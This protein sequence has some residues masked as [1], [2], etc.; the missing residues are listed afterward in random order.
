MA[1]PTV[2]IEGFANPVGLRVQADTNQVIVA[3]RNGRLFAVDLNTMERSIAGSAPSRVDAFDV[4]ADGQTAYV[5]GDLIGVLSIGLNGGPRR[6]LVRGLRNPAGVLVDSDGM[7]L[8]AE[9]RSP[10]RLVSIN[11]D[12]VSAV[13][14][15]RGLRNARGIMQ[16][17]LT[18]RVFAVEAGNGGRIVAPAPAGAPTVVIGGLGTPV[19]IAPFSNERVIVCDRAGRRVLLVD[20]SLPGDPPTELFTNIDNLWAAEPLGTDRL[21]IGAG[22]A[23]LLGELVIE[24]HDPVE[25]RVPE[26]EL[27]IGGWIR[28]QVITN[29][30]A[31]AFDDLEFNIEPRE[32]AAM[33]SL[34]RDNSFDPARPH[35]VLTAG[36]KPG[37]HELFVRHRPTGDAVG[38]TTFEVLETWEDQKLGPSIATFGSIESGP[39][40]GTWGGPDGGD[41]RVPQNVSVTPALGTRNVGVVLIDTSDARYPTGAALNTIIN[42][43]RNEM[44]NGVMI[45]GQNRSVATYFNQAS[46][47]LFNVNLVGIV[48]P[49]MLPNNWNSYFS[50]DDPDGDGNGIW[51]ANADLPATVIAQIVQLN[52]NNANAGNPPALDL[53]QMDSLIYVVRSRDNPAPDPDLFVWPRASLQT[54]TQIVGTIQVPAPFGSFE[55]PASRGIAWIYMPDDWVARNGVRQFHETVVH[56]IG[57]NLGLSDQYNQSGFTADATSRIAAFN[58]N[59]SWELMTW[60]RDLPLPSAAHRMM[61]G[62]VDPNRVRLYNFGVFGPIDETITLHAASLGA[63][64]AGRFAAAEVRLEDGKNYYFEYR[65]STAGRIVDVNPPEVNTVLGTEAEFRASKTNDHPNILRVEEDADAVMDLGAFATGEDFRDQDTTTPGFTNDFIVNV[66]NTTASEATVRVRYAPDVKPD[67]ALTPWSPSSNWQSPDIEVINGRSMSDSAFRNIPW[68]GHDNTVVARVTN[69]GSSPARSVKVKFFWKDFTFGPATE[70]PLGEQTQDIPVGASVTY[71]APQLW[72]PPTL[73]FVFSGI[74]YTQHACVV[75]RIDPFLDPVSNIWEVT[76]ENNEAQS[77]YTWVATTTSSPATREVTTILAENPFDKPAIVYF[78]IHQPHPLFRTY[79]DHRWVYLEPGEQRRILVM[80]ESLLG[81]ERFARVVREFAPQ[82]RRIATT[83]RLSALGDTRETCA[84]QVIGGV[85]I[86]AITGI[87]TRFEE[88]V[89]DGGSARGF[90]VRT[91]T[92][93]GINGTV[94]IT[95]TP[96]RPDDERREVVWEGPI[97]NGQ[98]RVQIGDPQEVIV[99]AHYLGRFPLGPSE[100]KP[101]KL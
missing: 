80:V 44:V 82:E 7:V 45:G 51:I 98:F 9:G 46:N 25:L 17:Q 18:G 16:E 23:L 47:G 74:T 64:P 21:I 37:K 101:A 55:V 56:E 31:I 79:L 72:R 68:E 66:V 50:F 67:P 49:I 84:P 1:D 96:R 52:V 33:V 75:A 12:P 60:E 10:G 43:L 6:R 22:D 92:R 89:A 58:P 32:A 61:L 83:L 63:A 85:S 13:V 53:S 4:T 78:T 90:V 93:E 15:A 5:A 28:V 35:I 36:W 70:Q 88:F 97:I 71:T 65:P 2:I 30:P 76:P 38:Q 29:D 39:S 77:N 81:D 19:D 62:W 40:G 86:L 48:G 24:E 42:N 57:H 26:G 95:L 27:F 99:Q 59:Q 3:Q 69:R 100:S 91:D 20:L 54:E 87:G 14:T 11:P 8:V 73:S 34:S 41:F 94:L